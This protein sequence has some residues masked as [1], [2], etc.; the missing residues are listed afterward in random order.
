MQVSCLGGYIKLGSTFG[1]PYCFIALP[2]QLHDHSEDRLVHWAGLRGQ[3]VLQTRS[4]LVQTHHSIHAEII[5]DCDKRQTD[6]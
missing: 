1:G 6:T 5:C 4:V 3:P 2:I